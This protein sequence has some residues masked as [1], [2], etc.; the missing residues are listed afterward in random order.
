MDQWNEASASVS[1][2]HNRL[3]VC[4]FG[5]AAI[6]MAITIAMKAHWAQFRTQLTIVNLALICLYVGVAIGTTDWANWPVRP[7]YQAVLTL[8]LL[9]G[10]YGI[11]HQLL[12]RQNTHD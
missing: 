4:S 10:M 11:L 1:V 9:S 8:A 6:T 12:A 2:I 7:W 5:V 3:F